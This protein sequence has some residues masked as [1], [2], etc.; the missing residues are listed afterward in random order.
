MNKLIQGLRARRWADG[1]GRT[2]AK[3]CLDLTFITFALLL[4]CA[5][6]EAQDKNVLTFHTNTRPNKPRTATQA[7][8]KAL[9]DR[10]L[11]DKQ[12]RE[13]V[14]YLSA[15]LKGESGVVFRVIS[16]EDLDRAVRRL[17]ADIP[18]LGDDEILVRIA[19]IGAMIQDGHSGLDYSSIP[20]DKGHIPIRFEQYDD[21]IYVRAAAPEYADAVGGKL[22][23]VGTMSWQ[24][25][26]QRIKTVISHDPENDGYPRAWLAKMYLN[27]PVLLHGLGLSKSNESAEYIIEKNGSRRTFTMSVSKPSPDISII[28][29]T[30]LDST[31]ATWLDA[32]PKT[33]M[34]PLWKQRTGEYYWFIYLP[35]KRAVYFQFNLVINGDGE[36]LA[37]FAGRLGAFIK[38]HEVDRLVIDL[39]HNTGGDNT[40]LRPLLVDLIRAKTN[41]RGGLYVI[42]SPMTFSAAQNFINRLENYTEVIFIGAPT[43]NNVNFYGDPR[44]FELPHS[45]LRIAV[46]RLWWQDKDP[47]D[48]RKSTGPL[49]AVTTTFDDYINGRDPVLD[50]ALTTTKPPTIEEWLE[51]NVAQGL[52]ATLASYREYVNDPAHKYLPDPEPRVNTL[53]YKFLSASHIA[54]A[55]VIFEVN[56]RTHPL[57][58]NAFDSLGE[59]YAKAKNTKRA[60]DAY[61][62]S[63]ELDPKNENALR[64]IKQLRKDS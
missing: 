33:T 1:G 57:S 21:G 30:F 41:F 64:M 6:G 36:S 19:Q 58:S 11:S 4:L 35:E 2:H 5:T 26:A 22:V 37:E 53:G 16:R 9:L 32:R 48:Y 7:G 56:A 59:A 8:S 28:T 63:L 62:R 24:E 25:A 14:Q 60:L 34:T 15:H 52:D 43:G 29:S 44:G 39:R 45:H 20:G 51:A 61:H 17:D 38:Q 54:E 13:D 55:V 3:A 42:I 23:A 31:P 18:H 49:L 12:W 50:L 47:R 27:Y 40:L 46:A 10:R